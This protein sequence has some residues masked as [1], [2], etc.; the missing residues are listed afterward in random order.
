MSKTILIADDDEND[1]LA[2]RKALSQ[3]GVKNP[4]AIVGDGKQVIAYYK[5]AEA[6]ADRAKYPIPGILLLDLKMPQLGGLEV[7]EW[8]HA[9]QQTK[10][11]LI[12][13]LSGYSE[14]E[15]I[16]RGYALGARSFLPKPCHADDIQ[17]LIRAYPNYWETHEMPQ[18][19][20]SA[21]K[22]GDQQLPLSP[23]N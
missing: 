17:G 8:L 18:I 9:T 23:E 6:Y 14:L 20:P 10:D 12:V 21:T 13:I 16:R 4:V 1:A 2:L 7:L 15:N 19:L 11:I 22:S 3:A 5:G